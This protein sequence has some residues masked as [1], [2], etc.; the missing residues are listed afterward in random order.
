M[1]KALR[2]PVPFLESNIPILRHRP[3]EDLPNAIHPQIVCKDTLRANHKNEGLKILQDQRRSEG[4]GG[5]RRVVIRALEIMNEGDDGMVV[6][7]MSEKRPN[8]IFR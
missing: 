6:I 7:M 5:D 4:F 2:L 1:Q 8:A 3:L